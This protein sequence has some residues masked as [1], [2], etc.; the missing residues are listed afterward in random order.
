MNKLIENTIHLLKEQTQHRP[1]ENYLP[2]IHIRDSLIPFNERQGMD[3][4][5]FIYINF[6]IVLLILFQQ[7]LKFGPRLYNI[8]MKLNQV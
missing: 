5:C 1:N 8:S 3:K 6:S 7:N 4:E 2:I